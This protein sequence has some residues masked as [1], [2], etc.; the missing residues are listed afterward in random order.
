MLG[1]AED[2]EIE[3]PSV[4]KLF[5]KQSPAGAKK[6]LTQNGGPSW[7]GRSQEPGRSGR[8]Q[9]PGRSG[10][11]QQPGGSGRPHQQPG[12]PGQSQ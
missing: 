4:A 9:Q 12:G 10:W 2:S 3:L 8:L 6:G 1:S 5:Q 11:S 7:S